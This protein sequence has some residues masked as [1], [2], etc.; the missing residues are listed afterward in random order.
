MS[1]VLQKTHGLGFI[2]LSQEDYDKLPQCIVVNANEKGMTNKQRGALHVW[3]DQVA[4]VLNEAGQY[5]EKIHPFTKKRMEMPWT[6]ESVKED[7]YKPTLAAYKAKA[8]TED[9]NTEEPGMIAEALAMAYAKRFGVCL[10]SWP[11]RLG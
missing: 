4:K 2:A 8:S 6:K 5:H 9:Q 10:P 1:I 11:S 3:C 7:L